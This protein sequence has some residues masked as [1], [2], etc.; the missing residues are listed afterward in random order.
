MNPAAVEAQEDAVSLA[1]PDRVLLGAVKTGLVVLLRLQLPE[2]HR[3]SF[4]GL[5]VESHRGG[6]KNTVCHHTAAHFYHHTAARCPFPRPLR[7]K[8]R[9]LKTCRSQSAERGAAPAGRARAEAAAPPPPGATSC[10]SYI[11]SYTVQSY[12]YTVLATQS[13]ESLTQNGKSVAVPR[14]RQELDLLSAIG[15]IE[16]VSCAG[17]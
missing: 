8:K 12:M 6:A 13:L 3:L 17:S 14:G 7:S 15:L 1:R 5:G 11:R 2:H 16:D 9:D 10:A 4:R